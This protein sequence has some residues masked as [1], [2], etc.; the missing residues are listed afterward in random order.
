MERLRKYERVSFMCQLELTAVPD[1]TP[2]PARALDLSLGGVGVITQAH[3][4]VGEM[5]KVTFFLKDAAHGESKDDVSGQVARL[6]ADVDAN[7]L[8]IQFLNPLTE[9]EHARLVGKLLVSV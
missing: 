7:M 3:F 2:E 8:G 5:V 1:G 9:A 6:T 4:S